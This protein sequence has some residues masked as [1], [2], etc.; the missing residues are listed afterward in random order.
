MYNNLI[1][2]HVFERQPL[3]YYG[4]I[5]S[6]KNKFINYRFECI[7]E[8]WYFNVKK[9]NKYIQIRSENFKEFLRKT[10]ND[11]RSS[12]LPECFDP[13]YHYSTIEDT[14]LFHDND[15]KYRLFNKIRLG[16]YYEFRKI[17]IRNKLSLSYEFGNGRAVSINKK[18]YFKDENDN[19]ILITNKETIEKYLDEINS[20]DRIVDMVINDIDGVFLTKKEVDEVNLINERIKNEKNI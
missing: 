17:K 2:T 14:E 19:L 6:K 9:N 3:Y 20:Y 16:N 4:L 10:Y 1:L 18:L 7:S 8:I 13:V 5:F 11:I 15:L 12:L